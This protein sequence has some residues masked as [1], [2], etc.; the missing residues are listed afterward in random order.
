[1]KF[2]KWIRVGGDQDFRGEC[3]L[4]ALEQITFFSR[5]RAQ[6]P[7]SYGLIALHPKNEGKRKGKQFRQLER[8][9]ILGLAPGAADIVIPGSTTFV[10]EMKRR[11]HT[12]CAWQPKQL[13]Y[14]AQCREAGAF[15]CVAL[16]CDAAWELFNEWLSMSAN[17]RAL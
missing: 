3:P 6:Y 16:G 7:D 8:D 5:L 13:E 12:L 2:P 10:C 14:L 17:G 4:E 15:V 11:D 9:K 1:M